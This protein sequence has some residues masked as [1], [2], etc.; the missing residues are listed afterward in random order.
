MLAE[1]FTND[2][3]LDATEET[4]EECTMEIC[5]MIPR[6]VTSEWSLGAS[7]IDSHHRKSLGTF[8]RMSGNARKTAGVTAGR[9]LMW[10]IILSHANW[11]HTDES[12]Y[13]ALL[14]T[15]GA[16][17]EL[18]QVFWVWGTLNGYS[19]ADILLS[20]LSTMSTMQI[21]INLSGSGLTISWTTF[22]QQC[23]F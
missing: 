4:R 19:I 21:S 18:S 23:P 22:S 9:L 3:D 17:L 2:R 11:V 14:A 6:P 16:G 8:R 12:W 20:K 15:A 10:T 7:D 1:C 5:D 13:L